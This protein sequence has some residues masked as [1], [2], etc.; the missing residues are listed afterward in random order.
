MSTAILCLVGIYL[1][2]IICGLILLAIMMAVI[3]YM[4]CKQKK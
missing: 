4:Y 2:E 3:I 1:K